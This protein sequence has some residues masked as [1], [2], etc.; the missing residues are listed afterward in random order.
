MTRWFPRN[1]LLVLGAAA[2]L[3]AQ[4]QGATFKLLTGDS[5]S[6]EPSSFNA[7][8]VVFK[9]ADGNYGPRVA[10]TNLTQEAL[11]EIAKV[12]K[13]RSAASGRR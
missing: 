2:L 4:G 6:G 9:L 3:L 5:V 11:R 7:V 10:F 12:A 8:G 13:P 1:A